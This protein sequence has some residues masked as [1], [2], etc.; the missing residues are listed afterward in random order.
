MENTLKLLARGFE[1][2][3]GTTPA[4]TKYANTFKRELVARL[5]EIGAELVN[6]NR[7]HFYVSGFFR[8]GE[9][10]F[11]FSQPDVRSGMGGLMGADSILVRTAKHDRDYTGG[12][13]HYSRL[14]ELLFSSL[15]KE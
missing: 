9:Q 7:G 2:S 6:F 15:P 11:Y 4:F 5:E 1:S 12:R 14:G 3:T 13:N 8:K 10:L